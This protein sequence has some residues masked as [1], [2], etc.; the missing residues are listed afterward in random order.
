MGR[1][2]LLSLTSHTTTSP[3]T[4]PG[5]WVRDIEVELKPHGPG[6]CQIVCSVSR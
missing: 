6:T 5:S 4:T 3:P 2:G 1:A